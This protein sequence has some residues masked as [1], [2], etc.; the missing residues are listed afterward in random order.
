M[1]TYLIYI[2]RTCMT[3]WAVPEW[4]RKKANTLAVL[5]WLSRIG[6][7]NERRT[8]IGSTTV[9][10][11]RAWCLPEGPAKHFQNETSSAF[12]FQGKWETYPYPTHFVP[13]TQ[14]IHSAL[15][16][17]TDAFTGPAHHS[18]YHRQLIGNILSVSFISLL[19]G[20]NNIYLPHTYLWHAKNPFISK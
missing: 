15:S 19:N 2:K 13:H 14:H 3:A 4:R 11:R 17:F 5:Q 8:S 7:K 9:A 10:V 1:H 6:Q 16:Y 12:Q 20:S 18:K